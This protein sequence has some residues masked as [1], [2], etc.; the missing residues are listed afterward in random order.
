MCIYI[1][2]IWLYVYTYNMYLYT[3]TWMGLYYDNGYVVTVWIYWCVYKYIVY[4]YIYI[5]ICMDLFLDMGY[6]WNTSR[7]GLSGENYPQWE[8]QWLYDSM[9]M[10][11]EGNL[12]DCLERNS[13]NASSATLRVSD[14]ATQTNPQCNFSCYLNHL[15]THFHTGNQTWLAA[16]SRINEGV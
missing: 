2:C 12:M 3:H 9:V 10:G 5:Y 4:K 1:I 11:L 16:K 8:Y 15:Q 13:G 7:N 6:T 14:F